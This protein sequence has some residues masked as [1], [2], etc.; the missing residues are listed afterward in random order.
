MITFLHF[1]P[2]SLVISLVYNCTRFEATDVIIKRSLRM[3]LHIVLFMVLMT[4][5]LL[6]CSISL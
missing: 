4:G 6:R 5:F 1:I 2:L 3:F